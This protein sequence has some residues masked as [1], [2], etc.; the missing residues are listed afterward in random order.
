[1]AISIGINVQSIQA[2]RQLSGTTNKLQRVYERLSSGQ[3][4]NRAADDAA[5]LSIAD[6]LR[7]DQ[8]IASVA[9]NNANDGI[10]VIAIADG[11]LSEI[12]NV[13][14]RMSEL[15][16]Q[17]ANGTFSTS[18][19]SAL[20][21]EFDLLG[22][23]VQRISITTEFNSVTLLSTNQTI[24]L[25]VGF[26]SEETSQISLR[27]VTATLSTIGLSTATSGQGLGYSLNGL[28]F[29]EAQSG[30]RLALDAVRMA[31]SSISNMRGALGSG[32]SRLR[33]AINYLAIARENFGAAESQI[34]DADVGI[35]STRD[36]TTGGSLNL[37]TG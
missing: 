15:S 24:V 27:N 17:S 19:R 14:I 2:Q 37:N 18:Q 3:R 31:I 35:N 9:I 20:Q 36:L 8:R 28:N 32:E 10:S 26:D 34:R 25:Q 12:T 4:I 21:T 23:E 7:A 16:E 30:S 13:L 6:S 1:M 22:S 11:A 33:T 5:G 29:A